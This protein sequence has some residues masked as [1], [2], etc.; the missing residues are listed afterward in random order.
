MKQFPKIV[1]SFGLVAMFS[2]SCKSVTD[3][4]DAAAVETVNAD[5]GS[6]DLQLNAEKM[7]QSLLRS[8]VLGEKTRPTVALGTIDNRT[9]EH[10]DTVLV[11]DKISTALVQSGKVRLVATNQ[12]QSEIGQQ[13]SHQQSGAVDATTAKAYGKQVGADYVLYGRLANI[14]KK[15]GNVEDVY[16][17]LTLSLVNVET[18]I[19]EWKEEKE[20]R[21]GTKKST[22]GW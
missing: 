4:G 13:I 3:Y 16:Y 2:Y 21:K 10:I 18:A 7:V 8:P 22:F 5:W 6:T 17:N 1:V 15:G 11:L 19:L 14:E 12:G 20:I 9:N